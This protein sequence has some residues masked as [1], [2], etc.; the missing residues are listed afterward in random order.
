MFIDRKYSQLPK[1]KGQDCRSIGKFLNS[2]GHLALI[3]NLKRYS[4]NQ[5]SLF[6]VCIFHKCELN[7]DRGKTVYISRYSINNV[8]DLFK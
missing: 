5:Y 1:I 3:V 8:V 6:H 2:I 4:E 7:L